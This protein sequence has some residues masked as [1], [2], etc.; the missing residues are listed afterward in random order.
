MDTLKDQFGDNV[1]WTKEQISSFVRWAQEK[2]ASQNDVL[3]IGTDIAKIQGFVAT[4]VNPRDKV[5]KCPD[6]TNCTQDGHEL[7]D[8]CASHCEYVTLKADSDK[9]HSVI[10][11]LAANRLPTNV[12]T[13][14]GMKQREAEKNSSRTVEAKTYVGYLTEFVN[15]MKSSRISTNIKKD[16]QNENLLQNQD[17]GAPSDYAS[18]GNYSTRK[19]IFCTK[20]HWLPDCSIAR[21]SDPKLILQKIREAKACTICLRWG[22]LA[23]N[24][25]SKNRQRCAYCEEKGIS[26][27]TSHRKI[28]CL[29]KPTRTRKENGAIGTEREDKKEA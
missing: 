16:I 4:L 10:T 21:K 28:V 11:V 14:A 8:H 29:N 9:L 12:T 7:N 1:L 19:C 5:C 23:P 2:P 27:A 18:G 15:N 22:H 17:Y 6:K 26:G 24:C 3:T 13:H 20:A 25:N